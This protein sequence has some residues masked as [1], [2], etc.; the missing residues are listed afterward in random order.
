MRSIVL[1]LLTTSGC[2]FT[3]GQTLTRNR[4]LVRRTHTE[5]WSRGDLKAADELYAPDFVAHWIGR[6]DTKGL[7][8]MKAF[9]AEARRRS[10]DRVETVVQIVADGDLVVTRFRSRGTFAGEPGEKQKVVTEEE[11]AIHRIRDGK[12]VEQW[13]A[14]GVLDMQ[15]VAGRQGVAVSGSAVMGGNSPPLRAK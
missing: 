5:V 4:E 7:E 6:P 14:G 3:A 13:T 12:I 1:I 2:A 10:P 9:V 11:I 15:P 8:S